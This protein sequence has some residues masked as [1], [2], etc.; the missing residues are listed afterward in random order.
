MSFGCY[1]LVQWGPPAVQPSQPQ[2]LPQPAL[3]PSTAP[4]AAPAIQQL[5]QQLPLSETPN[6]N[7]PRLNDSER[8]AVIHWCIAHQN[9]WRDPDHRRSVLWLDLRNFIRDELKHDVSAPYRIVSGLVRKHQEQKLAESQLR[10]AQAFAE[11]QGGLA[12]SAAA[13]AATTINGT[14]PDLSAALDEWIRSLM[15]HNDSKMKSVGA[16][17]QLLNAKMKSAV[18]TVSDRRKCRL[19]VASDRVLGEI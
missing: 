7:K 3:P 19:D 17:M 15:I 4:L 2:S 16:S 18:R 14:N 1:R 12:R 13:A 6:Q 9:Q 8:I 11:A 10:Q 5:Q